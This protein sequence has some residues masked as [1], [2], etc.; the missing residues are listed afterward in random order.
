MSNTW[1]NEHRDRLKRAPACKRSSSFFS[2]LLARLF[3][4]RRPA[5]NATKSSTAD[6]LKSVLRDKSGVAAIE[7]AIVLPVFLLLI[8]GILAYG[9]YFGAAHGV[10]QLAADAAR[11]SVAG[12]D[13]A[14][15]ARLAT[16][17]INANASGFAFIDRAKVTV[18]AGPSPADP[19]QFMVDVRYDSSDLP[20]W[21]F[22]GLVP[23]PA[24]VIERSSTIRRGGQ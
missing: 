18:A 10:A 1:I 8:C 24:K 11:V 20:I 9:I 15:R 19:A 16:A 3:R 14:E 4:F 17:H 12:L 6:R 5:D 21:I 7:F 23:L 22:S 2:N 13:D